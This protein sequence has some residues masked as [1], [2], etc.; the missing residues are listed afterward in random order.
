MPSGS[1]SPPYETIE[2]C[3]Q[4]DA[5]TDSELSDA[6]DTISTLSEAEEYTRFLSSGGSERGILTEPDVQ[7]K[8][9]EQVEKEAL[10]RSKDHSAGAHLQ[11]LDRHPHN[12][13]HQEE[14]ELQ[15]EQPAQ[16]EQNH[17]SFSR[18]TTTHGLERTDSL[19]DINRGQASES[20]PAPLCH[21]TSPGSQPQQP[22]DPSAF[23]SASPDHVTKSYDAPVPRKV[24]A[25]RVSKSTSTL[26][27][28]DRHT[29]SVTRR[30]SGRLRRTPVRF[31]NLIYEN[32]SPDSQSESK[33]TLRL[34]Y[35]SS[36]RSTSP[37]PTLRLKLRSDLLRQLS[38]SR[39]AIPDMPSPGRG[40][41]KRKGAPS[42]QDTTPKKRVQ[43][44]H[45]QTESSQPSSSLSALPDSV[46]VSHPQPITGTEE[47]FLSV[48]KHG[49]TENYLWD[50]AE[51]LKAA[52]PYG[53]AKPEPSGQP[54][55]WA[56][57]RT[58]LCETLPYFRSFKSGSYC[59]GGLA[60]GYLYN[61]FAFERDFMDASVTI[62]RAGGGMGKDGKAERSSDQEV[63]KNTKD[64]MNNMRQHQPVVHITGN[65]N[66]C[67]PSQAPRE[68]CVLGHYKITHIWMEKTL[69]GSTRRN[70]LRYRFEKLKSGGEEIWWQ[71]KGTSEVAPRGSLPPPVT[72]GCTTCNNTSEQVY[73]QGWMC[74][75]EKCEQ[76]WKLVTASGGLR[77]PVESSLVLDPR[78]LKQKAAPWS[79]ENHTFDLMP[80]AVPMNEDM[81]AHSL[82]NV[83]AWKGMVCPRCARCISRVGFSGWKCDTLG[84]GFE[85]IPPRKAISAKSMREVNHHVRNSYPRAR[86]SIF[87]N[88]IEEGPIHAYNYTIKSY[89]LPGVKAFVTH[90]VPNDNA[91]TEPGG[92]DDM[93]EELQ[94]TDV[95]LERRINGPITNKAAS[96]TRHM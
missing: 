20:L 88:T 66:P 92:P 71:P 21:E 73:L 54:P 76:H 4:Q 80:Y 5:G 59:T 39:T 69:E 85:K 63:K 52:S 89:R 26:T 46:L 31:E 6:P 40:A 82:Y 47:F 48:P 43:N 45:T 30:R 44:Q 67:L 28:P 9:V 11:Q 36:S 1:G 62:S 53:G 79:T 41:G 50:V 25:S 33:S 18:G 95:G 42:N 57:R 8:R 93:F 58:D 10:V 75:N 29:L 83:H 22:M 16:A 64:L 32:T 38:K 19:Q 12:H 91:L 14:Q 61:N 49:A 86:D 74:L 90:M 24:R 77:D 23:V 84:C 78:F 34:E 81:S 35:P 87:G 70:I 65:D 17:D 3:T 94:L 96:L 51:Q 55:I 37:S 68:Y 7:V 27:P 13:H 15:V 56:A 2:N 72:H 60:C